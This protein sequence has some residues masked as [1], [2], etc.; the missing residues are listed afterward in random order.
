LDV[1]A[2][3]FHPSEGDLCLIDRLFIDETMARDYLARETRGGRLR[4]SHLVVDETR[5]VVEVTSTPTADD[6]PTVVL[7]EFD[8][9]VIDDTGLVVDATTDEQTVS[10]DGLV[11]EMIALGELTD[12]T[13][14]ANTID[15]QTRRKR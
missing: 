1:Y 3:T 2:V 9:H 10:V 4:V 6:Q 15:K 11:D 12:V 8:A 5:S 13:N 14:V 7:T